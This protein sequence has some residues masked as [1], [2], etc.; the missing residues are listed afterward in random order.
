MFHAI[1]VGGGGRV[2]FTFANLLKNCM[3]ALEIFIM[4]NGIL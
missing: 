1:L 3:T 2:L 4:E